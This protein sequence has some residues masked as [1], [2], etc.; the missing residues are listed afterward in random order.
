MPCCVSGFVN[1]SRH[2]SLHLPLST[3]QAVP[4]DFKVWIFLLHH[5]FCS[6]KGDLAYLKRI[7][8]LQWRQQNRDA[9]HHFLLKYEYA[10]SS[11]K[12]K[13]KGTFFFWR[14]KGKMW[15]RPSNSI[16]CIFKIQNIKITQHNYQLNYLCIQTIIQIRNLTVPI[17]LSCF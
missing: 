8:T 14:N 15:K 1:N 13:D 4:S 16:N 12:K 3:Q 11:K 17:I 10:S 9:N 5:Q 6:L 7:H 2:I